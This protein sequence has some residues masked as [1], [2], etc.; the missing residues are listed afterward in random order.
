[1]FKLIMNI[2]KIKKTLKLQLDQS[3]CGVACLKSIVKYYG[4][5][6]SLEKLREMSGTSKQGTTLLGLYQV[7]NQIGFTAEGN[8]ADIQALIDHGKPVILHLTIENKLQHYVVCYGFENNMFIIGDPAKGIINYNQEELEKVWVSKACLTLE[9]NDTFQKKEQLKKSKRKWFIDLL[10]DDKEI[11]VISIF[12][13]IAIALLGMVMAV[14]SQK[15]IDEILPEKNL[16]KLVLSIILVAILLIARAG[17]TA[18]RQFL[19]ITQGKQFNNRI[20]ET[21]YNAL[22]Y[23]PKSFFDTRK[24]GEFVARLNDT[25]RIQRVITQ[26][27]GNIIID[28]LIAVTS[29]VFLFIYSW[30]TGLIA[31]FSMPVYFLLIFSFNKRIISSQKEVM[32]TYAMSESNYINT[33]SGISEIKNFNKQA[34]FAGLNKTIYGNFQDKVFNLGKINIRLGFIAGLTGV[35]FLSLVL[36]YNSY[37]VYADKMLIGALM[38]ILSVSST[39]L[40][41]ISNL[42]LITIPIN[43]AKVAFNRMYEFTGISP[44]KNINH[45]ADYFILE[46][47][48]MKDIA[49]RFPGRKKI[50]NNIGFHVSKGELISLVGESGSGKSTIA[51][52]LQKFYFPEN[53]EIIINGKILFDNVELNQWRHI[54]GVVPQDIHLFNGTVIENICLG[55]IQQEGNDVIRFINE[56]GFD[57]YINEFPQGPLTIIG[58]EGINLSGGQKQIIALA[59][60]LYK[61]PNLLILDEAT[62]AM[63]RE[64]ERFTLDLLQKMKQKTAIIYISH[65]LHVLKNISDRIYI[66]HKGYIQNYGTHEEL[67]ESDNLYSNYWKDLVQVY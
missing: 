12:I 30:Q 41:S 65:R 57:K 36:I 34:F 53:G 26:I 1:M 42:A 33:L 28:V 23:L 59:R 37:M 10:Q 16:Q 24:K 62:A 43:E 32:A 45:E 18:I 20:I 2:K 17:F 46:N 14:F 22:L 55:D 44:E 38:A 54:L 29:T 35:V 5:D 66:L 63:D 4:G 40:P 11:L 52:I 31:V 58:E 13:G 25:T 8:E 49:F 39:L 7:A 19:L 3:D 51:N 27:V 60:A 67:L 50:L 15:L 21:F 48:E 9:P 56:L 47:L 61:N 6:I 64:T